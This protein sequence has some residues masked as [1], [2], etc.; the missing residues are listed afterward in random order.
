MTLWITGMF[1]TAPSFNVKTIAGLTPI[2]LYLQKLSERFQLRAYAL[3]DNH[4]L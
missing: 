3:L 2:Q 4:I 1:K